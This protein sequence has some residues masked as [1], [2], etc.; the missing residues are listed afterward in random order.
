MATKPSGQAY[1]TVCRYQ[2][3]SNSRPRS[4]SQ[5]PIQPIATISTPMP[6]IRRKATNTGKIGGRSSGLNSL[7]PG[8]A[9]IELV[10]ED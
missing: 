2:R 9:P 10:G 1:C 4:H 7:R 8:K 6:T 3:V 5:A